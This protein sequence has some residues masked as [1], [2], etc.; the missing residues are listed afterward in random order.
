M[1]EAE[2][3]A[4][5]AIGDDVISDIDSS[6][7]SEIEVDLV[8]DAA[9]G[10]LLSSVLDALDLPPDELANSMFLEFVK[11]RPRAGSE[12]IRRALGRAELVVS[13]GEEAELIVESHQLDEQVQFGASEQDYEVED[14][15]VEDGDVLRDIRSDSLRQSARSLM[16]VQRSLEFDELNLE[17]DQVSVDTAIKKESSASGNQ[18]EVSEIEEEEQTEEAENEAKIN[19]EASEG[20]GSD[21]D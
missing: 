17:E 7:A 21:D 19:E 18:D 16:T 8:D 1:P 14:S 10:T 9:D 15:L 12:L 5:D 13:V 11:G 20:G 6:S 3:D 4:A 2:Q